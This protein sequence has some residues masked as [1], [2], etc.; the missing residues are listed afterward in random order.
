FFAV[1]QY[2]VLAAPLLF[3]IE[4]RPWRLL[5]HAVAVA[6]VLTVPFAL[7]DLRAF[8]DDL[9]RF[10]IRQPYRPDSL[11]YSAWANALGG[12]YLLP[13]VS[14]VT[15]AAA[16][17]LSLWARAPFPAAVALSFC[18]FFAVGKQAFCNYYFFVLGFAACAAG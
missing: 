18:A 8:I 7:P 5:L 14:F 15:L 1:K 2:A 17:A 10:Q 13:W 16:I 12:R 6:A 4:R 11:S 3:L 9:V